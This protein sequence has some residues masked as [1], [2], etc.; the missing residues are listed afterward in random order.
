MTSDESGNPKASLD[1]SIGKEIDSAIGDLIRGILKKP[2]EAIGDLTADGIGILG[3]RVSQKRRKNAQLGL[4][5]VRRRLDAD[6]V[7]MKDITPPKEEELH[8]LMSGMSLAEDEGV[9]HMW[10]GLFAKALEPNSNTTAER[11]FIGI[12]ESLSSSDAKIIDFL[13]F[14]ERTDVEIKSKS[15]HFKPEDWVKITPQEKE[16]LREVNKTNTDLQKTAVSLVLQKAESYGLMEEIEPVFLDNLMRLGIIERAPIQRF[17]NL[18]DIEPVFRNERDMRLVV[19]D[20]LRNLQELEN[21]SKR[22]ASLPERI[23]TRNPRGP[24]LVVEV[25]LTAFGQRFASACG[26]F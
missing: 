13:A 3:D 11:P 21:V 9:R 19:E 23:I 2:F 4:Q 8:L 18:S 24:Q 10:A 20:L 16:R 17:R 6:G 7:K 1:I 22:Q 5:V 14:I 26:L 12:L 15:I 25:K